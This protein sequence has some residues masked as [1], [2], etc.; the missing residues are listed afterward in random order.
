M[1]VVYACYNG[2]IFTKDVA[3][4][5]LSIQ[6]D[7]FNF[8]TDNCLTKLYSNGALYKWEQEKDQDNPKIGE[9]ISEYEYDRNDYSNYIRYKDLG[10]KQY[11]Y[12]SK[13]Y[14]SY[15]DYNNL[16]EPENTCKGQIDMTVD[17]NKKTVKYYDE[18]ADEICNYLFYEPMVDTKHRELYARWLSALILACLVILCD[19]VIAFFGLLLCSNF[20]TSDDIL[21]QNRE[22]A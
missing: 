20:G 14:K 17:T 5:K 12:N 8:N 22:V 3:Y 1:A 6:H 10:K 16:I 13:Y 15:N 9:Y 2:F 21:I 18:K 11:N 7:N 19:L 4:Q